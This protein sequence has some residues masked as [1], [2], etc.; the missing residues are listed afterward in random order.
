MKSIRDT[1]PEKRSFREATV[2]AERRVR[3]IVVWDFPGVLGFESMTFAGLP[4]GLNK[5][6]PRKTAD[7]IKWDFISKAWFSDADANPKRRIDSYSKEGLDD[8]V[9]EV[10]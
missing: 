7:V 5:Y 2:P 1:C 3:Y 6:R 9:R 10:I 4:P 8:V